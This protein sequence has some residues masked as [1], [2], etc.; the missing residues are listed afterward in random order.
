MYGFKNDTIGLLNILTGLNISD[1]T[2]GIYFQNTIVFD[3]DYNK[4]IIDIK[5]YLLETIDG[6]VTIKN[7]T[8]DSV[9]HTVFDDKY[10]TTKYN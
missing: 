8:T 3:E 2:T 7:N 1:E 4:V 6:I 10:N 9:F 5:V